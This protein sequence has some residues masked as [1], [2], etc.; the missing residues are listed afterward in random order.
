MAAVSI[1][2]EYDEFAREII[3]ILRS[4]DVEMTDY[5]EGLLRLSCEAWF[6]DTPRLRSATGYSKESLRSMAMSVVD[7]TL[8]DPHVKTDPG[9][10]RQLHYT[11]L[12]AAL[13]DSGRQALGNVFDKGF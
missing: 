4:H 9:V 3:R 10:R 6:E 5:A 13:V 12:M 11:G 7:M 1:E 8:S 2:P